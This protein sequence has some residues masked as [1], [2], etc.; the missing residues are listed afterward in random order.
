MLRRFQAAGKCHIVWS[1][2]GNGTRG[3]LE[4]RPGT[5]RVDLPS[6]HA[7]SRIKPLR[8]TC[9][10]D[11]EGERLW[12]T[13]K[14]NAGMALET[15]NARVPSCPISSALL[16]AR[17]HK[18]RDLSR[19]REA[20]SSGDQPLG[21]FSQAQRPPARTA[22]RGT[23]CRDL[24]QRHSAAADFPQVLE[25]H[26][27]D[28]CQSP[29]PQA[30]KSTIAPIICQIAFPTLLLSLAIACMS[31][32]VSL[33]SFQKRMTTV[34]SPPSLGFSWPCRRTFLRSWALP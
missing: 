19:Y 30:R 1:E 16:G 29:P 27:H 34:F 6:L 26:K 31:F 20:M 24:A 25:L 18:N 23:T 28:P 15:P 12:A 22:L 33:R 10:C 7:L 13:T 8:D 11:T 21:C 4:A 32:N 5:W 17:I 14:P 9:T 3:A 2:S